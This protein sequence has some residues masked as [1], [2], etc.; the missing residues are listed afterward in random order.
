MRVSQ[1]TIYDRFI[2]NQSS[3]KSQID[4]MTQQI[5]SGK[6]IDK[7]YQDAQVYQE[8]LRYD[9]QINSFSNT[10]DRIKKSK[11]ITDSSDAA[12]SN[13][14]D[15]IRDIRTKLIQASND[16]LSPDNLK[17]IAIELKAKRDT[18]LDLANSSINGQYLFSGT[19]SSVKPFDE[20]GNYRGNSNPLKVQLDNGLDAEYSITGKS[21]F[22]GIDQNLKKS[23]VNNVKLVNKD[24]NSE[25]FGK[26]L[27]ADSSIK[28]MFGTNDSTFYF[29]LNGT[30]KEGN[31]IKNK[32]TL[33]AN[34]KVTD[35]VDKIS[36][37][38]SKKVN[39]SFD[40]G[41]IK[42]EDQVSGASKLDFQMIGSTQ[43]VNN[44]SQ[45]TNSLN[46]N[47]SNQALAQSG[48]DDSLYFKK[49]DNK[50]FANMPLLVGDEIA[51]DTTKLSE[52][53]HSSLNGKIL[54]MSL[55]DI[56]G[57]DVNVSI[58]LNNHSTFKIG[59]NTYNIYDANPDS[60]TGADVPTK[61]NDFTLRQLKSIIS[62]AM[63]GQTPQSNTKEAIEDAIIKSSQSIKVTQSPKGELEI[64][65]LSNKGNDIKFSIYQKDSGNMDHDSLIKFNSNRAVVSSDPQ[66]DFFKD[67]DE[68][69]KAVDKAIKDPGADLDNLKNL[70]IGSSISKMDS[71]ISNINNG[72]SKIGSIT[73]RLDTQMQKAEVLKLNVT[74]LKSKVSDIDIAET[75]VKYQ[76]VSLSYQA[77]M[78]TIA[79]VNSLSLLN[80]LK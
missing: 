56:N 4:R 12:L 54:K 16:T 52:I 45:L 28:D 22:S 10:I 71:L 35:L 42:V 21:L 68:I 34:D 11:I 17:S 50:L 78:S 48:I 58:K 46:F 41:F 7:S 25:N 9:S 62:M 8:T 5:S 38:Y 27:T 24:Q 76:Q 19:A 6:Q 31:S 67:L 55:T 37:A 75:V 40:S 39:V 43:N 26:P 30:D 51:N 60:T 49:E 79:K 59:S 33:N 53:S 69:I 66:I 74:E 32:I 72:Q 2:S 63:S 44:T 29:Y 13:M 61:A 18:V 15:A 36:S 57:N 64:I 77:M 20:N 47:Q 23:V 3:A 14:S 65:D 80:Y 1:N 73:N 70:T